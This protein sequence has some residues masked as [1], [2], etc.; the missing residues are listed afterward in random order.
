MCW[1]LPANSKCAREM[2]DKEAP[3]WPPARLRHSAGFRV[4]AESAHSSLCL[5][6]PRTVVPFVPASASPLVTG[7][8][9]LEAAAGCEPSPGPD[10]LPHHR[11]R[12]LSLPPSPRLKRRGNNSCLV[13]PLGRVKEVKHVNSAALIPWLIPIRVTCC[14]RDYFCVN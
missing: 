9:T 8:Q 13:G 1:S 2:Q 14:C 4:T 6:G 12:G 11:P 10:L 7:S 5:V 3:T